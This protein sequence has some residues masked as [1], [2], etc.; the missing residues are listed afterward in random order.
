[1]SKKT[2]RPTTPRTG[3]PLAFSAGLAAALAACLL[4]PELLAQLLPDKA[5]LVPTGRDN[6][7]E[8]TIA[9]EATVL[10]RPYRPRFVE[11]NPDAPDNPPDETD[12][13]SF[14]DQ[15]SAQPEEAAPESPAETPKVKGEDHP[16]VKIVPDGVPGEP[17]EP[18]PVLPADSELA[19]NFER[20]SPVGKDDEKKDP[21][22]APADLKSEENDEGA[23][24]KKVE[25][26]GRDP[27]QRRPLILTTAPDQT[28]LT[29]SQPSAQPARP[30]TRPRPRPRL[31]ADLIRGPLMTTVADAP[32]VG[33]VAIECRLHPYGAYVQEMLQAI[34]DQWTQLAKGSREFLR[35]DRL[36]PKITLR[37]TLDAN[38]RIRGLQ[39][40]DAHGDSVPAE[41]C[42]QAIVSRVPFGKWSSKMIEDFGGSDEVTINFLYR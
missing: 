39:R 15:Q 9:W 10:P 5:R 33:K 14:R 20:G 12:N 36:P 19:K 27:E 18:L 8:V 21:P 31:G 2:Q 42:R 25:T 41:I 6:M 22:E 11:A 23:H 30:A 29:P 28:S 40:L 26:K 34:E 3:D 1:M 38:G 24:V 16:S 32:R 7:R 17:A 4:A 35:R 37:F 13:F